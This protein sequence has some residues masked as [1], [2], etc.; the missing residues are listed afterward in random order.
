MPSRT[1]L[2]RKEVLSLIN[3]TFLLKACCSSFCAQTRNQQ[4]H[5]ELD[6]WNL[7]IWPRLLWGSRVWGLEKVLSLLRAPRKILPGCLSSLPPAEY[8]NRPPYILTHKF[9]FNSLNIGNKRAKS[10]LKTHHTFFDQGSC[11]QKTYYYRH[12]Q[13]RQ[14]EKTERKTKIK[15]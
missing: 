6:H 13:I 15:K 2:K 5:S 1:P 7:L 9:T 3:L 11:A 14:L 4:Q 8:T 12:F 10:P